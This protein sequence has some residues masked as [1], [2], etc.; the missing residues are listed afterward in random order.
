M[1]L[2]D[3][4]WHTFSLVPNDAT[5]RETQYLY[6]KLYNLWATNVFKK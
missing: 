3:V 4:N 5:L 6:F 1:N 2:K